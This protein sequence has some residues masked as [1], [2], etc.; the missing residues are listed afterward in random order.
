MPFVNTVKGAIDTAQ[1]GRVL[2]HEHIFILSTEIMQNF[3]TGWDEEERVEDAI[4][5]LRALKTAGIDTLVDQTP[6]GYGRHMPRIERIA[7]EVDLHIIV[8]TGL[9]D[10]HDIPHYFAYSRAPRA[11][12][13]DALVDIFVKEIEE[14]IGDGPVKASF[15]K[16]ATAA[17]GAAPEVENRLVVDDHLV[18][19]ESKLELTDDACI[20]R[21][22]P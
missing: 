12:Q 19:F 11:G 15:I 22:A 5:K 7:K 20:E 1:L 10:F 3:D 18:S 8:P 9:I 17:H 16:V 21:A 14:G 2:M 13:R 6:V 4:A